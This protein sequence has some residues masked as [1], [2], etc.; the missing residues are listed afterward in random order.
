MEVTLKIDQTSQQAKLFLELLRTFSFVKIIDTTL[1]QTSDRTEKLHY[2]P[3][4]V[5]KIRKAMKQESVRI[6][7]E[8]LW[9]SI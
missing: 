6:D 4:F 7:R 3:K 9:E 1:E 8:K 2:N 5:S